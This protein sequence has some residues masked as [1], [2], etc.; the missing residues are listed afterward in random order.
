MVVSNNLHPKWKDSEFKVVM[1]EKEIG[2]GITDS[3]KEMVLEVWDHDTIGSGIF[4]GG[5]K[6]ENDAYLYPSGRKIELIL[7][8][9][10]DV[11]GDFDDENVKNVFDFKWLS[12]FYLG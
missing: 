11:M 10:E 8:P 1:L 4:L 7:Q 3:D 9:L 12:R 2:G 6:L 5:V